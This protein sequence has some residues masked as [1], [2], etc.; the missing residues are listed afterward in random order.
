MTFLFDYEAYCKPAGSEDAYSY[1]FYGKNEGEAISNLIVRVDD[2]FEEFLKNLEGGGVRGT[3]EESDWPA[4]DALRSFLLHVMKGTA[5]EQGYEQVNASFLEYRK[6][7]NPDPFLSALQ[8]LTPLLNRMTTEGLEMRMLSGARY[9]ERLTVGRVLK[10]SLS[11]GDVDVY[12]PQ[13]EGGLQCL[14]EDVQ[15][16]VLQH[17]SQR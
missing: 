12:T 8:R 6:T 16:E 14:L 2:A 7:H 11:H 5:H 3:R 4:T 9:R 15:Q 1:L 13:L 17:R 10:D